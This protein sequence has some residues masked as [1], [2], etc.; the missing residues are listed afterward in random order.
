MRR[1]L[2]VGGKFRARVPGPMSNFTKIEF[3][4]SI[5]KRN[6]TIFVALESANQAL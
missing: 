5:S 2:G 4:S 1:K 6:S 3:R